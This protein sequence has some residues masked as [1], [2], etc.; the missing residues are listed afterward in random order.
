MMTEEKKEIKKDWK[1][2]SKAEWETQLTH[3][4]CKDEAVV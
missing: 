3:N 1:E 2:G 4:S